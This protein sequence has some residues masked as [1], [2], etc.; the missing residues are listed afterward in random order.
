MANT[1]RADPVNSLP[2]CTREEAPQAASAKTGDPANAVRRT[3]EKLV[4]PAP[5]APGWGSDDGRH[6]AFPV[7]SGHLAQLLAATQGVGEALAREAEAARGD[8][9]DRPPDTQA[10]L[11]DTRWSARLSAAGLSQSRTCVPEGEVPAEGG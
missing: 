9:N 6:G 5:P 3:E 11:T 8:G 7:A 2:Q 1:P 4:E 10:T